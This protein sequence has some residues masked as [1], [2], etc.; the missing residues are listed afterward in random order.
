MH[1]QRPRRPKNCGSRRIG[2]GCRNIGSKTAQLQTPRGHPPKQVPATDNKSAQQ[3]RNP[4]NK[5]L[6]AQKNK[7]GC[8]VRQP[9]GS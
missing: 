1:V 6:G 9:T 5:S 8:G 7:G 4:P 2:D 3:L